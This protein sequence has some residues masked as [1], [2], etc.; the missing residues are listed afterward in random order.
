MKIRV[1][2]LDQDTIYVSR[3]IRYFITHYTDKM[4]I[5]V[6]DNKNDF[7][8]IIQNTKIDILLADPNLVSDEIDLPKTT[9]MAYLSEDS[10]IQAIDGVKVVGKYQRAELLYKEILGLYAELDQR[11]AY[12]ETEGISSI[13]FFVGASGGVGTTTMAVA[14]AMR[15]AAYGNKVLY[16]NLEENGVIRPFLQG[17]GNSTMSD[18]LYAVKSS[19][20]NLALKLES[21]IRK[22]EEGVYFYEPFT[23]T[24]DSREMTK[25]DLTQILDTIAVYHS[26]DF[27]IVDSDGT[28][29]WKRNLLMDY[30]KKI[31]VI[32]DGSEISQIKLKRL[33]QETMIRDENED[34]RILSK[35]QVIDNRC[36]E[37]VHAADPEYQ[38]LMYGRMKRLERTAASDIAKEIGQSPFF[39][40]LM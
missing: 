28:G 32:N 12:K 37:N 34:K 29:S 36:S 35:I 2:I 3:L 39:D 4:E 24:L 27:I 21:M 17:D 1:G 26:Y 40:R 11:V 25:N 23:V 30:A 18:V 9:I 14:C 6:F 7:L 22:S 19:H 38:D 33:L 31:L 8:N 20:S 16:L 15:L 10:E 13:Y 5:S